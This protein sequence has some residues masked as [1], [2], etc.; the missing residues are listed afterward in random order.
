[1]TENTM[2][3][4]R[5]QRNYLGE[6][7]NYVLT[8]HLKKASARNRVSLLIDAEILC[9]AAFRTIESL[10]SVR[11]E[12]HFVMFGFR[13]PPGAAEL[14][15]MGRRNSAQSDSLRSSRLKHKSKPGRHYVLVSASS[16]YYGRNYAASPVSEET[17]IWSV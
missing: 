6:E 11:V 3:S 10:V 4:T 2:E 13:T 7:V 16:S 14:R 9:E 5:E 15:V 1:M 17:E 8:M 12:R